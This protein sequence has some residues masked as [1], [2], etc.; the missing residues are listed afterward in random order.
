MFEQN[1][2]FQVGDQVIHSTHGLGEIIQMDE[3]ELFGRSSQ[4]YVVQV[5][6]ITLWVPISDAGV[7]CLR[8]LTPSADFDKL[9]T[10]LTSPGEPL[11]PDRLARRNQLLER[12]KDSSLESVCEV[13]RDLVFHKRNSKM[14]ENDTSILSRARKFLLDEWSIVLS[15]P[16]HQA[17]RE[18]RDLLGGEEVFSKQSW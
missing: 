18:L 16:V 6:D 10:I 4:Y 15:I 17:E 12:L 3:K 14:N 8:R 7:R 5:R 13:V 1:L 2:A 11:A 9:F